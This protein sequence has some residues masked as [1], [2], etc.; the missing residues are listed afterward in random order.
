VAH[1]GYFTRST[2]TRAAAAADLEPTTWTRARW[3]FQVAYLAERTARYLPVGGIN[4]LAER[5]ALLRRAYELVIP[6]NLHDSW[7]V[8]LRRSP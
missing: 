6:V 4:R 1:V 8:V 5:T 3:F 2:L 7:V